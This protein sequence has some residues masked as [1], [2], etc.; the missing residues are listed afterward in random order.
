[1]QAGTWSFFLKPV[2][3]EKKSAWD[4]LL[5]GIG[6]G[7]VVLLIILFRGKGL[8]WVVSLSGALRIF[9]TVYGLYTARIGS[10]G[11]VAEDIVDSLGLRGNKELEALA[12]K[13]GEES[14]R[15]APIDAS[16]IATFIMVLFF[17]HLGRMGFDQ[18]AVGIVSP[19]IA[20]I[21]DIFVALVFAFGII[22]P[23]RNIFKRI[24]GLFIRRAWRW[25]QK[26]PEAERRLFSLRTIVKA[27]LVRELRISI[28]IRKSGYSF[29]VAARNGLKVGLPYAALLAAI[30]PVLGMS[31]YFDTENWA[32]GAWDNYAGSRT[33]VWREAMIKASGEKIGPDAFRLHPSGVSNTSDFSFVIIGDPGEGDP[34]QHVLKDQILAVSNKPDIRFV[35]LSSDIVYPSGAMKDYERKFFLPFKG[36][37][38]PVYAIPGN[39]DWYDA[40]DAFVATFFT[41]EAAKK[42]IEARVI[43][44]LKV[45]T[46]T[47]KAIESLV[48]QASFLRKEYQLS[49]GH[50]NAPFFQISNDY[51]VFLSIDTGVRRKLDSIQ[52]AWVK[53][54]LEAS[55]GKYVMV[56]LGH[57]FYAI[58]E[59]QGNMNPDFRAIHDLLRAYK[60]P[61]IMAGD[62]HDLEYYKESGQN[63]DGHTMHHFVNGG[64]G[65]YLSIGAAMALAG[66]RP[67]KD[68]AIYPAR[69]PL[70]Q[71]IDSLTPRWKYPGL[72]MVKKI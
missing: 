46:R 20:A 1:M 50:Q 6:N 36:L 4:Y 8:D 19:L 41:P 60:V 62:T 44:D 3:K 34:S 69:E 67:T 31:W 32:S 30:M 52:L 14:E 43:S 53:S 51:F 2:K 16:W 59:Y 24:T 49:S 57:P 17:I 61:L 63:G 56:L 39:H 55:K 27:W 71:K 5:S 68:W 48:N 26:V 64:G 22:A 65:A 10:V 12:A 45:T 23:I 13:L 15:R 21:G 37:T 40:L 70:M 66:S 9:G 25:V 28:S 11:K 72:G 33:E 29:L 54:V 42:A 35:V 58:G 18:S 38:K 7:V 47:P